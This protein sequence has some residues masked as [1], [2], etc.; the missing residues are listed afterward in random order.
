MREI[1][2]GN[3]YNLLIVI[4]VVALLMALYLSILSA[5]EFLRSP[6]N[7]RWRRRFNRHVTTGLTSSTL[8]SSAGTGESIG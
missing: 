4:T 8:V 1:N 6:V 5:A 2:K 3:L 7:W